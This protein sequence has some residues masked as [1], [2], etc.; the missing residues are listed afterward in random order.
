[1]TKN[2]YGTIFAGIATLGGVVT[3][4]VGVI[5][6][7]INRARDRTLRKDEL[8]WKKT[9]F[10]FNLAQEFEA[11]QRFQ[12]ALRQVDSRPDYV[13]AVLA[14]GPQG[15]TKARGE[16][17]YVID[18]F[19]DFFDR[20]YQF[21][22]TGALGLEDV[23]CFSGYVQVLCGIAG[24][25]DFAERSGY[26]DVLKLNAEFASEPEQDANIK[27]WPLDML[28]SVQDLFSARTNFFLLAQSVAV[29]AFAAL[30]S[31]PRAER[32]IVALYGLG[33]AVLWLYIQRR[34][35]R[36]NSRLIPIV[37][38]LIPSYDQLVASRSKP[39]ANWLLANVLPGATIL[40]W[41]ALLVAL[42]RS[43]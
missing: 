38:K 37:R 42:L 22:G 8:S 13:A 23:A 26:Q 12:K 10:V 2:E 33:V 17:W 25:K 11:D 6:L 14:D 16:I 40:L 34:Q 5:G 43:S 30:H 36:N 39:P 1:M 29:I 7:V 21:I 32:L 18:R 35:F 9:E 3:V 41:V 24:F 4:V 15:L 27:R 28:L 20:L 19:C 31:P